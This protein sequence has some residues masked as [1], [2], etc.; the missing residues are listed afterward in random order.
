MTELSVSEATEL[1]VR[2]NVTP[3]RA[4]TEDDVLW[5]ERIEEAELGGQLMCMPC[6]EWAHKRLCAQCGNYWECPHY[7]HL[8]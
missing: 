7:L 8:S 1:C 6:K 3:E 2:R 5:K 4:F